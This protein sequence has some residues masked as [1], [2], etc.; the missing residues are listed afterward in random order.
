MKPNNPFEPSRKP[1]KTGEMRTVS[2]AGNPPI[3]PEM[4]GWSKFYWR[5]PGSINNYVVGT[6]WEAA[7]PR[8]LHPWRAGAE[9]ATVSQGLDAVRLN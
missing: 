8:S 9:A 3:N 2:S 1:Q 4:T 5:K 6:I 7:A